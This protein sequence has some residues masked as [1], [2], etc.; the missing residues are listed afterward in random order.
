MLP[1]Y[2]YALYAQAKKVLDTLRR[3]K[4]KIFFGLAGVVFATGTYTGYRAYTNEEPAPQPTATYEEPVAQTRVV[5]LEHIVQPGERCET[6]VRNY[7]RAHPTVFSYELNTPQALQRAV[8]ETATK[9]A[10]RVDEQGKTQTYIL[11][12]RVSARGVQTPDGETCDVIYPGTVLSFAYNEPVATSTPATM[13]TTNTRTPRQN[14]AALVAIPLTVAGLGAGAALYSGGRKPPAT[15]REE[16]CARARETQEASRHYKKADAH[17]YRTA[18]NDLAR[19][20]RK[21]GVRVSDIA[22]VLGIS[23]S[24]VYR[25]NTLT[26]S[27]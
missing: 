16:Y 17:T 26:N 11:E 15:S 5:R 27:A 3:Q 25:L 19:S 10:S 23:R 4:K 14:N 13:D 24:T 2:R 12:D 9:N 20:M 1:H 21:A 6:I 22:D 8:N 18:R 7:A